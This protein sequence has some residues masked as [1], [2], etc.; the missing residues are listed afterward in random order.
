MISV[1][2]ELLYLESLLATLSSTV[3]VGQDTQLLMRLVRNNLRSLA[4]QLLCYEQHINLKN[5]GGSGHSGSDMCVLH[6]NTLS[7]C[8][9]QKYFPEFYT[10][11]KIPLHLEMPLVVEHDETLYPEFFVNEE[12][13][14]I[15]EVVRAP[16]Q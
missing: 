16:F 6:A 13:K 15:S 11:K 9:L 5:N 8:I 14:Y 2:K 4:E 10:D 7:M 1:R 12:A 3:G